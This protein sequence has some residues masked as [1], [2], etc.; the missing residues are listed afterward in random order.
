MACRR[1]NSDDVAAT[2]TAHFVFVP[3]MHHGHLIPAVDAAM[4]LATHGALSSIVVTPTYAARLRPAVE[5]SGLPVRLVELPL[6]LAGTDDVDRIP[7]DQEAAYL[8]AASRLR[9]PLERHLRAHAPPVTCVVSDICHPWTAGLAMSLGV[10]RLSFL[11]MSAYCLLCLQ[12]EHHAAAMH[13][14]YAAADPYWHLMPEEP[15]EVKV[16]TAPP[17]FM[18]LPA[19]EKLAYEKLAYAVERACVDVDG[20]LLN[21]FL[22][23]EPGTVVD[24]GEVRSVNVWAVGPVSLF[25]QHEHQHSA[26]LA[27]RGNAPAVDADE[28]LRWLDGKEPSSVVYVSFG[29]SVVHARPEQVVETGLGLEASGHPFIWVVS[30]ENAGQDEDEEVRRFLEEL[31]GRLSGRGLL[32]K[33]W[34]PQQLILSHASVGGIVTHCGW[35]SMMEAVA[36]GLPVATWPHMAHQFLNEMLAVQSMGTGVSV[37]VEWL[38]E[39]DGEV[40]VVER[41]AV[42]KAVRS[43]MGGGDEAVERRGRAAALATTAREAVREGGSAFINLRRLVKRYQAV[44]PQDAS[45]SP[46]I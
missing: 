15:V 3:L 5:S 44:T 8:L 45:T 24:S 43:I 22:E 27:A 33:G 46:Q 4:Q 12:T 19:S 34:A 26:A 2:T 38:K 14:A 30:P 32:I 20:V 13:N 16:P 35:N 23:L 10:P 9:G 18:R 25:H 42:E 39:E 36:A 41:G 11:G 40:A 6:D 21:T 31:E 29:S 1:A 17:G 7:L 37:G 28:C